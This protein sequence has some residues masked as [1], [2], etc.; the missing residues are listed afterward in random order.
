MEESQV[1]TDYSAVIIIEKNISPKDLENLKS[2]YPNAVSLEEPF[3]RETLALLGWL[4]LYELIKKDNVDNQL[5]RQ[6]E[7]NDIVEAASIFDDCD[8]MKERNSY[9][10][11]YTNRD[12]VE[13]ARVA[14]LNAYERAANYY[15]QKTEK[16]L[17]IFSFF[18]WRLYV[19][20]MKP[21]GFYK[22]IIFWHKSSFELYPGL[23]YKIFRT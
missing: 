12:L 15:N 17:D 1:P 19:V 21:A 13:N 2:N 18:G 10:Y 9:A 22:S 5:E 7:I 16:Y 20:W 4:L 23:Y 3:S 6:R 14:F 11:L 8:L